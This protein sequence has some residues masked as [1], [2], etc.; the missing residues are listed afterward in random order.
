MTEFHALKNELGGYT[1]MIQFIKEYCKE[2]LTGDLAKKS[3]KKDK[4]LYSHKYKK[5]AYERS[6]GE[7]APFIE[8]ITFLAEQFTNKG[9]KAFVRFYSI[10][11]YRGQSQSFSPSPG[12]EKA[13]SSPGN[14]NNLNKFKRFVNED[15]DVDA[16]S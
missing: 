13:T 1:E 15:K 16:I 6:N 10:D 4:N 12:S 5:T 8:T 9:E 14:R 11:K 3:P 7:L 2:W